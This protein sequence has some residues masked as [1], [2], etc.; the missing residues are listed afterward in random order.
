M[1]SI[2][3]NALLSGDEYLFKK[4]ASKIADFKAKNGDNGLIALG[5]GDVSLPLAKPCACAFSAAAKG[6]AT[7][8]GFHGY[9]PYCGHAFLKDALKSEY[10]RLGV[11]L[12]A[13]EIFIGDGAKSDLAGI[14][15][16]FSGSDVLIP[17][18]A[19]PAYLDTNALAGNIVTFLDLSPEDGFM[20]YP[21][22]KGGK[23]RL[24]YLCSPNNPTGVVYT[25]DVL[26]AWVEYAI[27]SG[28]VIVFDGAYSEYI[29][30]GEPRSIYEIDGAKGCAI[31]VGSFSKRAGF[32]GVRC[33]WSVVPEEL[34]IAG[35]SVNATKKRVAAIVTNGV[36]YPVQ[37]AACAALTDEGKS[38][39]R[40][41]IDYYL[42]NAKI[43]TDLCRGLKIEFFGG[44]SSPYV[45]MKCPEN[46]SSWETFDMLLTK[47][48]VVCTPG[49]GFG[50]TG[51]GYIRLTAF[52]TRENTLE[53]VERLKKVYG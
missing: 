12:D 38:R 5:I 28:S 14:A 3:K 19:Y 35:K 22:R 23:S 50:K 20:P 21:D 9:P 53:A 15:R 29:T 45:F 24:I 16:L 27:E 6:M 51:E 49:V 32:T 43:L 52:N 46:K 30:G 48:R 7:E 8:N 1:I 44:E 17:S 11:R 26:S 47:A 18:P 39:C 10:A 31:E 2:N 40:R 42:T 36:S 37:V 4:V 25:K 41:Q 33:G 13:D 34:K